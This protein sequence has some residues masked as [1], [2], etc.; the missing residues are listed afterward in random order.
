MY[1]RVAKSLYLVTLY[2]SRT[3]LGEPQS[4]SS[5]LS[6]ALLRYHARQYEMRYN[7]GAHSTWYY[8]WHMATAPRSLMRAEDETRARYTSASSASDHHLAHPTGIALPNVR[9]V[10]CASVTFIYALIT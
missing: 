1:T 9:T 8:H 4:G 7:T 5:R 2:T 10:V 3:A 6:F